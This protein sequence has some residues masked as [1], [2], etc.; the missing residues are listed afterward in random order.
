MLAA[1]WIFTD[2][3]LD[4][5]WLDWLGLGAFEPVTNDYVPVFPWF[6]LVLLGMVFARL[7]LTA[8]GKRRGIAAGALG[9]AVASDH[10]GGTA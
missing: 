2:P 5:P 9:K 10:L 7:M 6:A 4:A 8:I 1:P 3:A